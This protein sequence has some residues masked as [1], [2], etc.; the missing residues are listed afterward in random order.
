MTQ[1]VHRELCEREQNVFVCGPG[2]RREVLNPSMY[3]FQNMYCIAVG[4]AHCKKLLGRF[5]SIRYIN[6]LRTGDA[7]LRFYIATVQDG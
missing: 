4:R 7:D 1:S 2:I 3:L 5:R 6:T